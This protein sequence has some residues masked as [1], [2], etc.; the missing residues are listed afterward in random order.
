M[1]ENSFLERGYARFSPGP[2]DS[3]F[4]EC[5]FQKRVDDE[6]GKKYFISVKKYL[7]FVK[8]GKEIASE[9]FEFG[10]NLTDKATDKPVNI[11]L[12]SG[13]TIEEA[14]AR[15]EEFWNMGVWRHYEKW[16]EA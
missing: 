5:L 1:N 4:V 6:V 9:S 7:P 15:A 8:D 14:E 2:Y 12:Y 11:N 16:N 10:I 3:E 13:W